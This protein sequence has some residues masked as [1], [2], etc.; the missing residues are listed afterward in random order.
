MVFPLYNLAHRHSR[1]LEHNLFL[2]W[3]CVKFINMYVFDVN[4][5]L[6]I[7]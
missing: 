3:E 4:V 2:M 6:N 1:W 7:P 5:A